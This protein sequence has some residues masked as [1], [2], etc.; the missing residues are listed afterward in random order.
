M[1]LMDAAVPG[2]TSIRD[3]RPEDLQVLHGIDKDCFPAHMAYS[4]AELL[5]YLRQP[6]SVARVAERA[7]SI[8][9]FAVG[10][11]EADNRAHIVT[12]DVV[13]KARR[14]GAGTQLMHALH[15]EFRR[16]DAA[17]VLLEVEAGN[18]IAQSFYA[19]LGYERTAIL[20]G[21]Y[22]GKSDAYRMVLW[23]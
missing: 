8:I 12:L 9:G 5:F 11:L 16:R 22:R 6:F 7:G 10:Q 17:Q 2:E 15:E 18:E 20:R 1:Q 19:G 13:R 3:Y 23:L 4:R 14:C 21:Y